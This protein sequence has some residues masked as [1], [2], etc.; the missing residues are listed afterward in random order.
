MADDL[1]REVEK[2][3][4]LEA[5]LLDER[6]F[7][8]WLELLAP[9]LRYWMSTRLNVYPRYSKSLKIL[10]DAAYSDETVPED[11][12]MVIMDET[13]DTLTR[14]VVCLETGMAWAEDPPS[15]TRHNVSNVE[16][17]PGKAEGE[18]AV[19]S[20]FIVYKNRAETEADLFVGTR[21]DVLRRVGGGLQIARRKI[22]LDQSVL[23]AKNVAIFF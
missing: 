10:D 5:R 11:Q 23:L 18:F 15:R 2:F 1:N 16:V 13:L 12:S 22:I 7:R 3:Y 21:R 4:Y 20:N 17:E 8:E 6:R 9:D 14:R 19:A